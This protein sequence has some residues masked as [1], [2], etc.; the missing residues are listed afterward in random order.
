MS[1]TPQKQH[2]N[3]SSSSLS[4][5]FRYIDFPDLLSD[6]DIMCVLSDQP[7]NIYHERLTAL[8]WDRPAQWE[9]CAADWDS[10]HSS[11]RQWSKR[12]RIIS[13]TDKVIIENWKQTESDARVSSRVHCPVF[14]STSDQWLWC[15]VEEG[16]L[17]HCGFSVQ[18]TEHSRGVVGVVENCRPTSKL[19]MFD[20][21]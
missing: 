5:W 15:V 11:G 12:C 3:H 4:W 8:H 19:N 20:L 13:D 10:K 16:V 2:Q 9:R 6:T 17:H 7:L 18:K 21:V 1:P 14:S